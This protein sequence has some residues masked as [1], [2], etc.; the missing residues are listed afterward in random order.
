MKLDAHQHFWHYTPQEYGWIG[1]DMAVLQ[2]DRLPGD[3]A[4]LLQSAGIGGTVALQARQTLA[5]S[6][7]LLELAN[8]HPFIKG[9]VG[10]VDLCSPE[11]SGQ[12]EQLSA[13]SKFRGVRHVIQDEPDDRF[14]L[15]PDFLHGIGLLAG[16][17]LTYD[18]L[19]LAR[20]LPVACELVARFPDQP[21]VLDHIAKP[22]IKDGV[23]E[24]WATGIRRLATFPNVVCKVSG[25]VTEAHWQDWLPADFRPYL[26]VVLKAFG[27]GRIMFGSDWPVC[28]L[29]SS[30]ADVVR[31]VS[32]YVEQLSADE[33]AAIWGGTAAQ[34]Y[35]LETR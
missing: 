20:H 25:M 10:W 3:L 18:I 23:L 22:L 5:E 6:R 2:Q 4:P 21:F 16:L 30:Y 24:P 27:P 35:G 1:S 13:H 9:V 12:L 14:M 17:G 15:R 8:R 33:Q 19:I 7:W 29:A 32:D 28:T 34:F 26:D 11:L 31:L